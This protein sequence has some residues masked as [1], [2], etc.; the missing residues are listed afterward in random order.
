M[1]GYTP[2]QSHAEIDWGDYG[3]AIASLES[4]ETLIEQECRSR[5]LAARVKGKPSGASIRALEITTL[6]CG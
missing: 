2:E 3:A 5:I 1:T 4:A 6:P